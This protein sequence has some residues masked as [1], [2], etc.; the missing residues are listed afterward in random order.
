MLPASWPAAVRSGCTVLARHRPT[1]ATRAARAAGRFC[2][3]RLAAGAL[4][5]CYAQRRYCFW[6]GTGRGL[7]REQ[8]ALLVTSVVRG[9]LAAPRPATVRSD[10]TVFGSALSSRTCNNISTSCWSISWCAACCRRLGHLL[11]VAVSMFFARRRPRPATRT[12]RAVGRFGGARCAD[13][14]L[15]VAAVLFWLGTGRRP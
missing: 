14:L 2:G 15:C 11:C 3:A 12:A 13:R 6:L 5:G 8:H 4:A 9:L 10:R 7:Q 1:Y